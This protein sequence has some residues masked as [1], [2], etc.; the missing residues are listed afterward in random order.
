MCV[1]QLGHG[2]ADHVTNCT[3][4]ALMA[5]RLHRTTAEVF[6]GTLSRFGLAVV[7]PLLVVFMGGALLTPQLGTG[8]RASM[9]VPAPATIA[10]PSDDAT[11]DASAQD[12][13]DADGPVDL[14]GNEVTDAVAK[15]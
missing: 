12:P 3:I 5:F 10:A 15:Y 6:V 11:N 2:A 9:S 7:I 1:Q 8:S 14:Y 4:S 13:R